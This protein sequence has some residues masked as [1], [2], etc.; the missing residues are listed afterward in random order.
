MY[1]KLKLEIMSIYDGQFKGNILAVGRTG[2]GKTYFLQKL[3][4]HNFFSNIA[5]T[6]WVSGIEIRESR[7][8]E[9]QSIIYCV[10]LIQI[11]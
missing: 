6:G 7:E 8:A 11:N 9:I 5:K 3:G 4:L 2:C 10:R 1:F